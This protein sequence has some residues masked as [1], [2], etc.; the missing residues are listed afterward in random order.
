MAQP[1]RIGNKEREDEVAMKIQK[2]T[3][4]ALAAM[5]LIAF[6][7]VPANASGKGK[8]ESS[9]LEKNK[10]NNGKVVPPGQVKRYTRGSKL[11]GD[12]KFKNMD[13]LSKWKLKPLKAGEK[14]IRVDNEVLKVAEDTQTVIEAVGIVDDLLR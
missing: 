12:L 11:P 2:F 14:Y 5:A 3:L 4:L 9:I 6:P 10:G 7:E 8:P 1:N 13:D